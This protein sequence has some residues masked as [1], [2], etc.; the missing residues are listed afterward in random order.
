MHPLLLPAS[1]T[2]VLR[3]RTCGGSLAGARTRPP[4]KGVFTGGY[5]EDAEAAAGREALRNPRNMIEM[6]SFSTT[7]TT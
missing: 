1:G 5:G 3:A 4:I 2:P 6:T 7:T